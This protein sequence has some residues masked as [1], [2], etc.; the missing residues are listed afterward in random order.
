MNKIE[1]KTLDNVLKIIDNLLFDYFNNDISGEI[2][3]SFNENISE[4]LLGLDSLFKEVG[5]D[6]ITYIFE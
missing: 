3:N 2:K 4:I 5:I 1:L 6:E